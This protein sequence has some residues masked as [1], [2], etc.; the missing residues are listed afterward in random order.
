MWSTPFPHTNSENL[1]LPLIPMMKIA[2]GT[3]ITS[4]IK[5]QQLIRIEGLM[6]PTKEV[7]QKMLHY[8]NMSKDN[9]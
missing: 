7:R 1:S 2:D 3:P 9:I 6:I 4:P 5:L 8:G